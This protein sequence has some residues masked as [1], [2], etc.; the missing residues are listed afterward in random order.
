M[1]SPPRRSRPPVSRFPLLLRVELLDVEPKVLRRLVVPHDIRLSDLHAALQTALGW[2]NSHLYEFKIA[3]RGYGVPADEAMGEPMIDSG[4]VALMD[5][6][7][8]TTRVFEYIYDFG[9]HWQHVVTVEKLGGT[10][11]GPVGQVA[12]LEAVHRVPPEN[13]GGAP[14]YA[15]FL[16]AMADPAHPEHS[17][18]RK[19]AGKDFDPSAVPIEWIR[20]S[21]ARLKI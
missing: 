10:W 1:P 21:L 15:D 14:G 18:I 16:A 12:L 17:D 19:W 20:A 5:A 3:G 9:D 6:I 13:V 8:R 11:D 7:R 4:R 2:T